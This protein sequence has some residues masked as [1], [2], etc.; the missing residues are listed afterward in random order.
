MVAAYRETVK[1]LKVNGY[2]PKEE[3]IKAIGLEFHQV[4]IENK[5]K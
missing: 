3:A 1:K 2:D 4:I 5:M